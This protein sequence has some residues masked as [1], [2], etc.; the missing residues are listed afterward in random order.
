MR[1]KLFKSLICA[2]LAVIIIGI[3]HEWHNLRK[4][5]YQILPIINIL[6]TTNN[7]IKLIDVNNNRIDSCLNDVRAK[8][9]L[10]FVTLAIADH[11]EYIKS[12]AKL[13]KSVVNNTHGV[14][15]DKI[16]LE[17]KE[18]PLNNDQ[19]EMLL[20]SGWDFICTVNR[21]GPI[22]NTGPV[23][24]YKELFTK[25]IIF[26]MSKYDG[27]VTMDADTIVIGNITELFYLYE[28]IDFKKYSI[29][30]G[31]D[32]DFQT[33]YNVILR[34]NAGVFVVRPSES[35]FKRLIR[36]KTNSSNHLD[37]YFAEQTFLNHW[38]ANKWYNFGYKYNCIAW[39]L[40]YYGY[41]VSRIPADVHVIHFT[42]LKPWSCT[43]EAI[44]ICNLWKN[45][46]V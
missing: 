34:F 12:A 39:H 20:N 31:P 43:R 45:I 6:N 2:V 38:Y 44:A 8:N 23:K 41:N 14:N 10:A 29:A 30:A 24:I 46:L 40:K 4:P 17:L 36:L 25:L 13:L 7:S 22:K 16:I 3:Y 11:S 9:K 33:R 19:K 42:N 26:N 28:K 5:S 35:E 32:I 27:I 21:I 1:H 37:P 15:Y 18:K